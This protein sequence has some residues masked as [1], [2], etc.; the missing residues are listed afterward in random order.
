MANPK[1]FAFDVDGPIYDGHLLVDFAAYLVARK[2]FDPNVHK[3][4]LH[5]L[6]EYRAGKRPYK[7]AAQAA[8][9]LFGKGIQGQSTTQI[10][11]D[12]QAFVRKNKKKFF[13]KSI[14]LLRRLKKQGKKIALLSLSSNELITAMGKTLK[15]PFDYYQ[16]SWFKSRGG[17]YT[18]ETNASNAHQFKKDFLARLGKRFKVPKNQVRMV[19]D[20]LSDLRSAT[21]ARI[22]FDPMNPDREL[23]K[24]LNKPRK[25]VGKPILTRPRR[26]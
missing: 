13:P 16:G 4:F 1:V 8:V 24:A 3:E 19:G 2:R 20:S 9:D 5:N 23:T 22:R 26:G 10:F 25:N 15:I 18:G 12:A 21:A 11:D 7:Q 17:H 14:E 6:A